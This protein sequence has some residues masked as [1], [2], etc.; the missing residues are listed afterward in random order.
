MKL[1]AL[2]K[3]GYFDQNGSRFTCDSEAIRASSENISSVETDTSGSIVMLSEPQKLDSGIITGY[4]VSQTPAQ[5]QTLIDAVT[6]TSN[7][8]L[9]V[10][11]NGAISIPS[12]N[13]SF[14]F[15][16]AGVA[17][18]TIVD[19]TATTHD[20]I[21]LTFIATTANANTLT[22]TTGFGAGGGSL[23][24]ATFGGAIGDNIEI[25]AYQGKWYVVSTRN[26]TLG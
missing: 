4:V 24:V 5:I 9:A 25:E 17:A 12:V 18:M 3:I 16:K 6:A 15:T 22:N 2:T 14:Y 20:G 23:D 11:A 13:T 1:I 21:R 19:P 26:V 8:V 10:S 7:A